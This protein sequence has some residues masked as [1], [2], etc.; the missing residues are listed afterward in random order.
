MNKNSILVLAV[1]GWTIIGFAAQLDL[2][3]HW[4]CVVFSETYLTSYRILFLIVSIAILGSSIF[5]KN[6][7]LKRVLFTI[8]LGCW[9][10]IFILFKGGYAVGFGGTPNLVV[11]GY[12]LAAIFLRLFNIG[13]F[14]QNL[15][16]LFT[17]RQRIMYTSVATIILITLKVT[18][19]SMPVF[20]LP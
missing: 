17:K 5:L 18:E 7:K 1:I 11:V 3:Q 6:E 2:T 8:E 12:D 14:Y 9:L 15:N 20:Y 10:T 4:G 19:F 13:Y 16:F